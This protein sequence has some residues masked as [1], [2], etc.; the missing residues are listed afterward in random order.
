RSGR[1]YPGA[2]VRIHRRGK[3]IAENPDRRRRRRDVPEESRMPIE[4]RMVEQQL[5]GLFQQLARIRSRLR[6]RSVEI[7]RLA[8][9]RWGFIVIHRT[10]RHGFE[11]LGYLID[12]TMSQLAKRGAVHLERRMPARFA[13]HEHSFL[14]G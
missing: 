12:E 9:R 7:Q 14:W 10:L 6:N 1:E 13:N 2:H 3:K 4:Q 11:E 5:C 8:H